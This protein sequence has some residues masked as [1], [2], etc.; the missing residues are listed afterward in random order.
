MTGQI[1]L[2][3]RV[4]IVTGAGRGLGRTH[5]LL[6]ADRG[7]A[8]LVNDLGTD[9]DGAGDDAGPAQE[10]VEQIRARGGTAIANHSDVSTP[11]GAR[12]LA[13]RALGEYGRIDILVNNAGVHLDQPFPDTSFADFERL[14]RVNVG[15]HVNATHAVWPAMLE[16]GYGR[17]VCTES[18]AGLYGLPGQTAYAATKGAL[19]GLMRCLALEGAPH[20][21]LVN[22]IAPGAYTR[23]MEAGVPDPGMREQMRVTMPAELTS[24]VV[25]W[26]ASDACTCAGETISAWG[27][28]VA[29]VAIGGNLGYV[30][31]D[32]LPEHLTTHAATI[33]APGA[34]H[35]PANA[36]D[37]VLHWSAE[38]FTPATPA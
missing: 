8:V 30:D 29:R 15:G 22:S 12:K 26:L 21:I 16:H 2:D 36:F 13:E 27:G 9:P 35:E 23:M 11:D 14:F 19:H 10:V 24:P 3:G 38:V 1:S 25:A 34:A 37:E 32:L 4:A 33:A 28:R 6:L 7:A 20:G 17:I 18:A 31:R 5:A